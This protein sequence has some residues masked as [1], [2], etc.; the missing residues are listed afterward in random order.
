MIYQIEKASTGQF[1][2]QGYVQL[3]KRVTLSKC[4]ELMPNSH[5]EQ[6]RGTPSEAREY[7]MKDDTRQ[8]GP[9]E[10]GE[11]KD[12]ASGAAAGADYHREVVDYMSKITKFR[13]LL[14]HPKYGKYASTRMTWAKTLFEQLQNVQPPLMN[15]EW[16]P[17]QITLALTVARFDSRRKVFWIVDDTGN[18]GKTHFTTYLRRNFGAFTPK[19]NHKEAAYLYQRE[20]LVVFD[21]PRHAMEY[22]PYGLI[23]DM[24]NG[25]IWSTKYEPVAK[26]FP[27]PVVIVMSNFQPSLEKLSADRWCVRYIVN[28]KLEK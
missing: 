27:P 4:R 1:H 25:Y 9:Y 24:K 8:S 20:P 5:L 14:A 22:V 23:E 19:L 10:Y 21:I 28:N 6:T 7:C 18:T 12:A 11:F 16:K 13:D 15:F 3:R 17:W 2:C 26:E